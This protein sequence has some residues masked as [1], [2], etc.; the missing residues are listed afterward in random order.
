[1]SEGVRDC[2]KFGNH[3]LRGTII[4]WMKGMMH[5]EQWGCGVVVDTLSNLR[6]FKQPNNQCRSVCHR[7]QGD[8]FSSKWKG[9]T[10]CTINDLTAQRS[11][12][13]P[14]VQQENEIISTGNKRNGYFRPWLD[15]CQTLGPE[16]ATRSRQRILSLRGTPEEDPLPKGH[17]WG[18]SSP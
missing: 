10:M 16:R 11:T 9:H 7:T 3:C 8:H 2:K 17:T 6:L 12:G 5:G 18:G 15:L 13:K 1:M 14:Y 4:I